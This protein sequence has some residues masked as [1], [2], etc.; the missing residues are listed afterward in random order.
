[1]T[2]PMTSC[3]P[4]STSEASREEQARDLCLRLLTAKARTRAELA[5]QLAKRG[6][7]EEVSDRVLDRLMQVGLVDD[8]DFAEQWVRSRRANAGKGRRAL[9]AELRTKGVDNDII[10]ATLF[11]D[12]PGAEHARAERLVAD[13]LRR[14]NS[15]T[16]TTPSWPVDW[17]GCSPGAAM[18]R[19]WPSMS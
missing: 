7:P 14:E 19:R 1:M 5:G 12:E 8:A 10:E 18:A 6:Y 17:W 11:D 4:R 15:P 9:I 3:P 16:V 13:K 2:W